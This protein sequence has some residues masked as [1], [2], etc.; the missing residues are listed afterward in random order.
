[1]E[2][3]D[4]EFPRRRARRVRRTHGSL[5][6]RLTPRTIA[7]RINARRRRRRSV[8]Q[9]RVATRTR[10]PGRPLGLSARARRRSDCVP[11]PT[12]PPEERWNWFFVQRA[13]DSRAVSHSWTERARADSQRRKA[14]E[15]RA[16]V[17]ASFQ[18]AVVRCPNRTDAR[19]GTQATR[20]NRRPSQVASRATQRLRERMLAD[21]ERAG[22]RVLFPSPAPTVR[23]TLR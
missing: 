16:D 8:R 4:L 14:I 20:R 13:K 6:L 3:D 15:R 2:T 23:T 19:G 9:S 22:L 7:T 11:I 18:E 21:G 17:A 12:L 1:M 5:S 10:V